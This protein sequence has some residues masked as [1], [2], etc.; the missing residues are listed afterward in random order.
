MRV[1]VTGATGCMGHYVASDLAS[2]GFEVIAVYRN[3]SPLQFASPAPQVLRCDLAE[4]T[5][6]P[7]RLD[8]VVH[9]A[10]T[11]PASGVSARDMVRDNIEATRR[12]IDHAL[13]SGAHKFIFCSSLSTLGTITTPIVDESNPTRDPELYGIT[14]LIGEAL[15]AEA[16]PRLAGLALRLPG[17]LGPNAKRNFLVLAAA[18][19][20][21]NETVTVFNP[22]APF[23]NAVH[24]AD[25]AAFCAEILQ[26]GWSGYD[27]LVVGAA[28][29]TTIRG[30]V[31]RLRER[32]GSRS[33]LEVRDPVKPAFI[34]SSAKAMKHYG[35]APMEIGAMLDRF[36]DDVMLFEGQTSKKAGGG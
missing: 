9:A 4:A 29:R 35:Y 26:H 15:L 28:G 33:S 23:N 19:L 36:A 3:K 10:A 31:E 6:L 1:L 5:G 18:R 32:L 25:I 17:V 27:S 20:R 13:A 21:A 14:K 30:A 7:E 12:L 24:C 22:D 11:S 16:A 8:A 34:L 2:R